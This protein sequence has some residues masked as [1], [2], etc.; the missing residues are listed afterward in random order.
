MPA[1]NNKRK[2]IIIKNVIKKLKKD[3]W[4]GLEKFIYDP[5]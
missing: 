1:Y 3:N 5:A 2:K 4:Y